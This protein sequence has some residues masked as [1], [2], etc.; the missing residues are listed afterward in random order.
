MVDAFEIDTVLVA[1]VKTTSGDLRELARAIEALWSKRVGRR[2]EDTPIGISRAV[3]GRVHWFTAIE[4]TFIVAVPGIALYREGVGGVGC[5]L[6]VAMNHLDVLELIAGILDSRVR[7][8]V[9][10]R[11][12]A[13]VV[14]VQRRLAR[15]EDEAIGASAI[16]GG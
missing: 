3:A 4:E 1:V 8:R 11:H 6:V 13:P 7:L 9:D 14:G 2:S 16:D 10:M 12:V 5:A 15:V